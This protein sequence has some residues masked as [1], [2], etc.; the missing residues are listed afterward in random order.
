MR[1]ILLAYSIMV[2][3]YILADNLNSLVISAVNINTLVKGPLLTVFDQ[4]L[5]TRS[6]G[7]DRWLSRSWDLP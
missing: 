7:P 5:F 2:E 6:P 4:P 3:G 1:V